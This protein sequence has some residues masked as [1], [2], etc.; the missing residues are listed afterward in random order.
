MASMRL[1]LCQRFGDD[2]DG[3]YVAGSAW[4]LHLLLVGVLACKRVDAINHDLD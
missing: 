2:L 3:P 4:H 1:S